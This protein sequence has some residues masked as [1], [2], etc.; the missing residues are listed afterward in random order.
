V[1]Y[2]GKKQLLLTQFFGRFFPHASSYKV[3]DASNL[4]NPDPLAKHMSP[5]AQIF[6]NHEFPNEHK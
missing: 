3:G 1:R 2:P 6:L 5:T 4:R